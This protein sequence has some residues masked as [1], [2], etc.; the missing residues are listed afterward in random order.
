M[1]ARVSATGFRGPD[2]GGTAIGDAPCPIGAT[3]LA[4]GKEPGQRPRQQLDSSMIRTTVK[5][6]M[7]AG[8]AILA[9]ALLVGCQSLRL[10]QGPALSGKPQGALRI[11]SYNVHYIR[12][13]AADGP[14]SRGDWE[15]RKRPLDA[16][17]KALGA[18]VVAFQEMESFS[19]GSDGGVNLALDWILQRN[20]DFAAAA[21]GDWRAFPS[22]QPILYRPARLRL[23][24]QGWYF[25]SDTPDVIY[26]RTFDGS[27]PAFAS[28]ARFRDL[29]SGED[30]VVTNVHLE[31]RSRSNRRLS[32]GL[33]VE[34]TAPVI[35]AG[36]RAILVGDLN[37]RLGSTTVGIFEAAGFAFQPVRGA[38]YHFNRGLNL[39]GAIDHIAI[40]G[41]IRAIRDPVVLRR[42]FGGEWPTD[43]YPVV[44][45]FRLD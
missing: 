21:T 2:H 45:D 12:L 20:P 29:E 16:A 37:A 9:A 24:D 41:D 17:F 39:F 30:V 42:K 26:S 44:G 25:F 40:S 5:I 10:S 43:H 35:A 33:I 22:T 6:A 7:I 31:Y 11:A 27:W 15:R 18:D 23:E 38:T 3:P 13:D 19:R 8:A 28:W 1:A 14:W 4:R 36:T 34:R 32:A